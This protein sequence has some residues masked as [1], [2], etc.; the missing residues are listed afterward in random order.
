MNKR[1]LWVGLWAG[2]LLPCALFAD[3]TETRT[4]TNAEIRQAITEGNRAYK[5]GELSQAAAQF[6][7]VSTLI[8]QLQAGE[9]GTLFPEPLTGWQA[10]KVDTQAGSAAFFGGGINASRRY[11]KDNAS[12]ELSITKDSPLLQ[13]MAVLFTNPSMAAMGGYKVKRIKGQTAMMKE[14]SNSRELQMLIAN[15]ILIQLRGRGVTEE[16]LNAYAEALDIE[17]LTRL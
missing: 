5:A 3:E 12:L 15:R 1:C 11:R 13:T 7:Y 4:E 6:D 8:R 10:E 9:L 2:L 17:A 16:D 14:E